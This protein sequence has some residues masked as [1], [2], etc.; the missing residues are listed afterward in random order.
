MSDGSTPLPPRL[1]A[2]RFPAALDW[3]RVEDVLRVVSADDEAGDSKRAF[4][5]RWATKD[6]FI[7]DVVLYCLEYKD[8]QGTPAPVSYAARTLLVDQSIPFSRRVATF[9]TG[10][11]TELVG[12]PR[13]YLLAHLAPLL[14]THPA[15]S[16]DVAEFVRGDISLWEGM[17]E[18][19]L[20]TSGFRLRPGWTVNSLALALHAMLDGL[21][22]RQRV[23]P[24]RS[25]TSTWVPDDFVGQALLAVVAAAVDFR[26][27]GQTTSEWVDG[28]V[29]A[30][31]AL[32][33]HTAD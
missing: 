30:G 7:R 21:V 18:E 19:V 4:R 24:E 2:I 14:L 26:G 22:L 32:A 1:R 9:A 29:A 33:D 27:T 5:N 12:N 8:F 3:L 6:D 15:L 25:P 11:H 31:Q 28:Q 23:D 10:L 17:Y 20:L 16:E 13:S